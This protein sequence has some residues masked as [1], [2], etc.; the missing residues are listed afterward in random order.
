MA[1]E[2]INEV[3][4]AEGIARRN[5]LKAKKQ[6]DEIVSAAEKKSRDIFDTIVRQGESEAALI[7]TEA[8]ELTGEIIK[9]AESI[10]KLRERKVISEVEKRY[11]DM[12]EFVIDSLGI[13]E[14]K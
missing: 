10:A 4:R 14:L 6:A 8:Q 9:Q 2:M 5:E 3:L 7:I 13:N 12:I 11:P 1:A